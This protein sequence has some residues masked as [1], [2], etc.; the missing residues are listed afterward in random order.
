MAKARAL[1]QKNLRVRYRVLE[2]ILRK[3]YVF[4]TDTV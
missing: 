4:F 3:L 2:E 1:K